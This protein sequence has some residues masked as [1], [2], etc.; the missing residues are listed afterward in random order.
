M[1]PEQYYALKDF[2]GGKCAIC[3]VATGKVKRLALDHDHERML[4]R[5]LLCG[6]CNYDLLGRQT[7]DSL[8]R[9]IAY[10]ESPPA[11]ELFGEM[12]MPG[13]GDAVSGG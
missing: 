8:R 2:Q 3:Q 5:G 12:R 7:L 11:I 10:L 1:T 4:W 13:G 9:A 6:R